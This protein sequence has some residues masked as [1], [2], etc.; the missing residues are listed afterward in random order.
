MFA[1]T[2]FPGRFPGLAS[3]ENGPGNEVVFA[4]IESVVFFSL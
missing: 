3:K 1:T 4:S 2:S